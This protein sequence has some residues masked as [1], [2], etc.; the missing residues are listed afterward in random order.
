MHLPVRFSYLPRIQKAQVN[1]KKKLLNTA[2]LQAIIIQF[3]S[4][5]MRDGVWRAAKSSEFLRAKG[6]RFTEDL[7][8]FDRERRLLQWPVVEKARKEGK[9]AHFMGHRAFIE[10][11]E[12]NPT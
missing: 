9:R 3:S 4:R 1:L 7:T 2:R 5:V 10:G 11:S 12:V 6:F 8:A